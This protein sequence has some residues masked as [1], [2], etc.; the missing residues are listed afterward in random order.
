MTDT[1]DDDSGPA[2]AHGNPEQG[3]DPGMT[4]RQYAAIK[5]CVPDSGV[6]WLDAMIRQRQRDEMA[7]RALTGIDFTDPDWA[8][9]DIASAVYVVAD[10]MLTER[11]K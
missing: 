1:T 2:F 6:D 3:G 8:S 7:G 11:D 9:G 10:A 5:L 4:L